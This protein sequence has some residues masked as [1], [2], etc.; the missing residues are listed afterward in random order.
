M[1]HRITDSLIVSLLSLA[2]AF[3]AQ[4]A[5]AQQPGLPAGPGLALPAA[6]AADMNVLERGPIHE[7]FAEPFALD[8]NDAASPV[9]D[10]E[11]PA[12]I[13][14]L[15][16]EVR[17][18]GNN[19]QWL[20]GYWMFS[21]EQ[22]DFIWISGVWREIPPGR[23]W[24]PG[25]WSTVKQANGIGFQWVS[26]FWAAEGVQE[27]Q[28]LPQPPQTLEL[29]PNLAAPSDQ[30]FWI[31][32]CWTFHQT[33]YA[34][35]PGYWYQGHANWIWTP[36]HYVATPRG[37]VYVA[38]YWDYPLANRGLLFAPVYWPGRHNFHNVS[39]RPHHVVNSSLLLTSLFVNTPY[40]HYYFGYHNNYARFG[41]NPWYDVRHRSRGAHKGH[42]RHHYDPLF[43]Y[44]KWHDG[45]RDSHWLDRYRGDHS[46][47]DH[48]NRGR[49]GR[50]DRGNDRGNNRDRGTP[51]E[52]VLNNSR[53]KPG[54][55]QLKPETAKLTNLVTPLGQFS[56][57]ASTGKNSPN[58]R[59]QRVNKQQE[60][61]ALRGSSRM[62]ELARLRAKQEV[63]SQATPN[64]GSLRNGGQTHAA[65]RRNTLTLPKHVQTGKP[66][67]T[68]PLTS[69]TRPL[70]QGRPD[71]Q[72]K[73]VT[74]QDTQL[75]RQLDLQQRE[76]SGQLR[77][78]QE[79]IREQQQTS[80][81][82]VQ[83]QQQAIN[84]FL[85]GQ[86][87][88]VRDQRGTPRDQQVKPRAQQSLPRVQTPSTQPNTLRPQVSPLGTRTYNLNQTPNVQDNQRTQ[89]N[90][91][92][93][94]NRQQQPTKAQPS[95]NL[96]RVLRTPS[97]SPST[98]RST[99]NR[100]TIKR[101]TTNRS[102]YRSISPGR[103]SAPRQQSNVQRRSQPQQQM[104]RSSGS[105]SS[106]SQ[107]SQGNRKSFSKRSK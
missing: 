104:R 11:P 96:P 70:G 60:Q 55:K 92:Q 15:P 21:E 68:N 26:G 8:V 94:Q 82:R 39:Y 105:S 69:T 52:I 51:D 48:N 59:L 100:P 37:Y 93:I 91:R 33:R 43:A 42:G 44:H 27:V 78:Q 24:M 25:H 10:L 31:P 6:D 63:V 50:S 101:S 98:T 71:V 62:R 74:S 29:G 79:P 103:S 65:T 38:G 107:K 73:Q 57:H 81:N 75:R 106:S 84:R 28:F 7:A 16:P 47:R 58:Q 23:Q 85:Q 20:G 86:Q 49:D 12:P 80:R 2:L 76:Q 3:L 95:T 46:A 18:E 89:G 36:D 67:T 17:P 35:R 9:I 53:G 99:T 83:E 45:H 102:T 30:H 34:W 54:N 56:Q 32:G 41:L 4:S 22:N 5:H 64:K 87:N 88:R 72:Q 97:N 19:V 90:R 77:K 13:E 40:R 1:T 61:E 14:E 66:I